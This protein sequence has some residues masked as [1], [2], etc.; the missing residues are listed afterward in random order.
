MQRVADAVGLPRLHPPLEGRVRRRQA[1][2]R[3]DPL[4]LVQ[5]SHRVLSRVGPAGARAGHRLDRAPAVGDGLLAFSTPDEA[6]AGI[7]RINATTPRTRAARRAEIRRARTSTRASC[8]PTACSRAPCCMAAR[9]APQDRARR[10]GRDHDSAAE[11]G[12]GRDDDVAAHRRPRRARPRRHAVRHRP[13]RRP[14]RSCTR[15]IRTATGTTSTMWPWELYEMLN[16]AAAVERA[17]RLR[18]HPLRSGVL[19]D[20]ARVR[21]AVADADRADAAPLAERRPRCALW[22]RYPEAPFVAISNEQARLLA[23][24]NVVGDGAARH[25]HRRLHLPRASRTTTCC[26]SAASPKARACCRRSRS[27]SASACG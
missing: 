15:S 5:R 26:S 20:V 23:G 7:D 10:S 11:I 1:H 6:L 17:A 27:P 22:S 19:P 18:H 24:L 25:R 8:C 12:L 21:A 16:L 2:L 3:R 14:A 4:G 9:Y 13:T